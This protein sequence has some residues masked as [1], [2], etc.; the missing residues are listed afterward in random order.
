MPGAMFQGLLCSGRPTTMFADWTG[1]PRAD[2]HGRRDFSRIHFVAAVYFQFKG[3]SWHRATSISI[4]LAFLLDSTPFSPSWNAGFNS[5][6][7]QCGET[8]RGAEYSERSA[9]LQDA[10][11]VAMGVVKLPSGTDDVLGEAGSPTNTSLAFL[12]P[13]DGWA[14]CSD[15]RLALG[16]SALACDSRLLPNDSL[17]G[18]ALPQPL[19]GPIADVIVMGVTSVVLGL[20]ILATVIAVAERLDCSPPTKAKR[21]RSPTGKLPDFCKWESCRMIPL[22]GGFTRSSPV[23]PILHSGASSLSTH[24]TLIASHDLVVSHPN[25]STT[26]L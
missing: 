12:E 14:N 22:V 23:S 25:L 24:F 26:P 7:L 4:N 16:L 3:L 5:G 19:P 9:V 2:S 10:V 11:D 15:L 6:P 1:P 18:S 20:L 17:N 13:G 21:V 8:R